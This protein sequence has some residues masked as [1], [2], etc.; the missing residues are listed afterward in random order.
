MNKKIFS[1]ALVGLVFGITAFAATTVSLSPVNVSVKEGQNF[2]LAVSINPQGVKNYTI[3]LEIKYP[4]DTLEIKSFSFGNDW[5]ALSQS[6]YDLID[7]SN[8]VLI[9]TAGYPGGFT[10]GV[11]FGTIVFKAKKSGNAAI[12]ITGNSLALNADNQNI[13]GGLPVETLVTITPVAPLEEGEQEETEEIVP[14]T[15][16]LPEEKATTT[17]QAQQQLPEIPVVEGPN[18]FLATVGNYITLGTENNIVG[19][20][21]ILIVGLILYLAYSYSVRKKK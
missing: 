17:E 12:Q 1:L 15:E 13:I 2:N 20:V 5:M 8:G 19:A 11:S 3:K 18:P 16:S 21:V 4:A 6:G 7:N 10:S 14:I 9:K